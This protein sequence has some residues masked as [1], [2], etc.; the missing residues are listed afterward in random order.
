MNNE[1]ET[2]VSAIVERTLGRT[3]SPEETEL[4]RSE[5]AEWDSLLHV[6]IIFACEDAFE[7]EFSM[8]E[9]TELNS[10]KSL[11]ESIQVKLL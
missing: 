8:E 3:F 10:I 7:V 6:E 5:V 11:V 9:L 2:K 1:I 4:P